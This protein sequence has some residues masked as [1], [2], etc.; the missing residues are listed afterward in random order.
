M[1]HKLSIRRQVLP[2]GLFVLVCAIVFIV[3]YRAGGGP[4]PGESGYDIEVVVPSALTLPDSA[5]VRMGGLEVGKV[6]DISDRS[7]AAVLA[8]RIDQKYGPIFRNATAQVRTKDLLGVNYLDIE[9]GSSEAGAI[10]ENGV[11]PLSNSDSP[12]QLDE[13]ISV[14]DPKT[15]QDLRTALASLGP[16]LGTH[17]R[18]LNSF[19]AATKGGVD[20]A[21][22]VAGIMSAERGQVAALIDDLGRVMGAVGD[23]GEALQTFARK[24][25]VTARAVSARDQRLSD[26]LELLPDTL[27]Q[28]EETTNRLGDF[29]GSATPVVSDLATAATRLRPAA[30]DLRP[31]AGSTRRMLR[32][33]QGFAG[34]G[35]PLLE[36]LRSLTSRARPLP[37]TLD[38]ALAELTPLVA[39]LSKYKHELG[40]MI[41]TSGDSAGSTDVTGHVMRVYGLYDEGYLT[42]VGGLTAKVVDAL[43]KEGVLAPLRTRGDNPYPKPGEAGGTKPFEGEYRR[44]QALPELAP[45]NG[46]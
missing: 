10:P 15:R 44:I 4:L 42:T 8:I 16:A 38:T 13:F 35:T 1:S 24:T 22:P 39:Y 2:L 31:A 6:T 45:D 26:S 14:L 33:L 3:L 34:P 20:A 46:H 28:V 43:F 11:L 9:P 37:P 23:R 21:R 17:G 30:R 19:L 7:G 41:A 25:L 27:T 5:D 36:D 18:D 32:A 29:A 40:S 12:T